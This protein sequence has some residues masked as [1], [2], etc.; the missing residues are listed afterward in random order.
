MSRLAVITGSS[1]G[2]GLGLAYMCAQGGYDLHLVA[3]DE[4]ELKQVKKDIEEQFETD[5]TIQ[6]L[7]LSKDDSAKKVFDSVKKTKKKVEILINNAG[8]GDYA[9]FKDADWNKLNDMMNLNVIALVQLTHLFTPV[10]TKQHHGKIMNLASTAAFIPGPHMAVYH[11]TKS[12]VLNFTEA[13]AEE[14]K[15]AGVTV[16]A[17]CPGPTQSN[18]QKYAKMKG[19]PLVERKLPTSEEVAEF[20]YDAMMDGKRVAIHG[21]GNKL[22]TEVPRFAP[23]KAVSFVVN[24]IYGQKNKDK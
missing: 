10:F 6:A 22:A 20:G 11:A 3:R 1:S 15:D 4:A 24:Q 13:I 12:F 5:V 23:R 9:M 8:F 2:I 21:L 18:F 16:T 14:L 17:L 19:V 7:D